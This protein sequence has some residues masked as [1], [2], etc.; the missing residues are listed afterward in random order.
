MNEVLSYMLRSSR[1]LC[2]DAELASLLKL[3]ESEWLNYISDVRG[4]IV[5]YP[6]MVRNDVGF[7][8]RCTTAQSVILLSLVVCLSVCM[9]VC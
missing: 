7:T 1:K 3:D 5:T 2:E 4:M 9:F 8:A 6:G